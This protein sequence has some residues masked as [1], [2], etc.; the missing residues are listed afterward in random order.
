MLSAKGARLALVARRAE[1]LEELADEI[2]EAGGVAPIILPADLGEPG[3]AMR[4]AAEAEEQLGVVDVL[5]NNAGASIQGL[6]W[7]AGDR[8]EA[9]S[10]FETNFWSPMALAAALV[11]KMIQRGEGAI[12]NTGS[13]VR[14]SPFPHLGHYSASRASLASITE[15]M[16]LEL[17]PRG[18]R[19]IEV[20]FGPVET[21]GSAENRLLEGG[22]EW[23]E[24]RP[25]IGNLEQAAGKL[26]EAVVGSAEGVIFY[27]AALRFAH[28][29]PGLGRRYSRAAAKRTD[30]QDTSIRVGGS[31]GSRA[32]RTERERWER[33]HQAS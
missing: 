18:I 19:V 3:A 26:V 15:T 33:E 16:R 30:L 14:V 21:A 23:L 12:I 8:P 10:V 11:P 32:V 31:S 1:R 17:G 5:V 9:R 29:L 25:G 4:L 28:A 20:A 2:A 27:P 24:G 13:M 6:S 22:A 7:V